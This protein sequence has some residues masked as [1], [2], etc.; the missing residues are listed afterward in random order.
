MN[1]K[2]VLKKYIITVERNGKIESIFFDNEKS[3][4]RLEK[5]YSG[6]ADINIYPIEIKAI[7]DK[8]DNRKMVRIIQNRRLGRISERNKEK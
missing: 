2:I 3:V 1:K 8:C 6:K 5:K 7:E 4:A